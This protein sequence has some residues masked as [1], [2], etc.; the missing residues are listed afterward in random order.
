MTDALNAELL[1]TLW[2]DKP[3]IPSTPALFFLKRFDP[4]NVNN[5]AVSVFLFN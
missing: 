5:H 2:R 3:Y 4:E 1:G